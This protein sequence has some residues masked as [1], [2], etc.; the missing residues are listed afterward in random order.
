M[1]W[2]SITYGQLEFSE[3]PEKILNFY[4]NHKKFQRPMEITIGTDSQNHK[5]GTK[6]VMV[7]AIIC[8]GKGGIFFS[9]TYHVNTIKNVREKLEKETHKSLETAGNLIE[10]LSENKKYKNIIENCPISIHIDAGNSPK[11]K[12]KD[13][14]QSL[15]G[16]VNAMGYSCEIKPNAYAA[17]CIADKITK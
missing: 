6:T 11:G 15:T 9:K 17:S 5:E 2:H 8:E 10:I 14:I 16:W 4:E 13:L 12:T 3:I 7:I 1:K